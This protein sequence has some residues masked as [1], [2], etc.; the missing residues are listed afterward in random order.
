MTKSEIFAQIRALRQSASDMNQKI[1]QLED[2]ISRL[3]EPYP[4]VNQ[5]KDKDEWL[6]AKETCKAL[7]ISMTT[8]YRLIQDGSLPEGF[9]FSPRSKRW[10]LS[11]IEAWQ[12]AKK[13][14]PQEIPQIVQSQRRTRSSKV[15]KYWELQHV[16][17]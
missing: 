5:G 17:A 6:T 15:K 7:K 11:D 10:R 3:S 4:E 1:N 9:E 16:S 2:L 13:D 14:K 12:K 8:F